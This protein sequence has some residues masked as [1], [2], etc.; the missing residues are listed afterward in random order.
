M[1]KQPLQEL[2]SWE[3][4]RLDKPFGR[5]DNAQDIQNVNKQSALEKGGG[6][7]RPI[8]WTRGLIFKQSIPKGL[9]G[10]NTL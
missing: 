2:R 7:G 8:L 9:Y 1:N 5:N 4:V 3:K 10:H 6:G